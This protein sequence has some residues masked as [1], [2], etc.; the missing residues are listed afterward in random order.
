MQQGNEILP[1]VVSDLAA[2]QA[3]E[4]QLHDI[5]QLILKNR[6]DLN[7]LLGLAP[8]ATLRLVDRGSV[9]PIDTGKLKAILLD[10]AGLR[11]DLLAHAAGYQAAE[12]TLR[13]A[14]IE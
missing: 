12:P 2:L 11:A 5:E 7:A 10:L 13:H 3:D 4:T 9:P 1:T 6:H 8:E 14:H